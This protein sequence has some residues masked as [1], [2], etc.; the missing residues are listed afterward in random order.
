MSGSVEPLAMFSKFGHQLA[1]LAL[2]ANLATRWSHLVWF[3]IWPP[4]GATC[5]NSKYD[6][7]VAPHCQG[8]PYWRSHLK[9]TSTKKNSVA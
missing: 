3:Q 5:I 1:P 6:H 7:Q 8:L 4:G 9:G 2:V